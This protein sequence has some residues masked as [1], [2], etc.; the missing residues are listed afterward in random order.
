M[1]TGIIRRID[2]LG[3]ILIP[4]EIRRSLAI[5]EGDPLEISLENNKICLERYQTGNIDVLNTINDY[6]KNADWKKPTNY[7]RIKNMSIDEMA[8]YHARNISCD[9]CEAITMCRAK[10]TDKDFMQLNCVDRFKL[11]LESEVE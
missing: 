11:W 10:H 3:R 4:K 1:K 2:D 7:E 5:K 9:R 6:C 8:A